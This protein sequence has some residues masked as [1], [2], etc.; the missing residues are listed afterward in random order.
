[1]RWR[2]PNRLSKDL[3]HEKSKPKVPGMFTK[4]GQKSRQRQ[5]NAAMKRKP[6]ENAYNT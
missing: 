2:G 3:P 4:T 6:W 1:M 5:K